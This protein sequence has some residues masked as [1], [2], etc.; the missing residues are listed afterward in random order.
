MA[1]PFLMDP[2]TRPG[3]RGSLYASIFWM[4]RPFFTFFHFSQPNHPTWSKSGKWL[5]FVRNGDIWIA[6]HGN[7]LDEK[8]GGRKGL[9]EGDVPGDESKDYLLIKDGEDP[10]SSPDGN[11]VAYYPTGTILRASIHGEIKAQ[12]IKNAEQPAW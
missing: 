12:L 6:H 4:M 8:A 3:H 11:F 9:W 2:Y 1:T 5:A 10:C 7:K